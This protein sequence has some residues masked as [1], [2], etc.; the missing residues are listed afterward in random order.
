MQSPQRKSKALARLF[1]AFPPLNAADPDET[2]RRYFEAIDDF[3][4]ELVDEAVALYTTGNIPGFDGKFVPTPPML[5]AGCRKAAEIRARKAYLE[6]LTQPALP[7]PEVE[8]TLEAQQRVRA[9]MGQAVAALSKS[10][11]TDDAA[12]EL[13]KR[14]AKEKLAKH[15]AFFAE[16][17]V[18]TDGGVGR[19]SKSLARLIGYEVGD[20]DG[21]R[22][23]A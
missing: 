10:E 12:V 7:A 6:R 1:S 5:A 15:D 8:R 17:F 23:V 14:Q 13:A 9:L 19:V 22:E 4:A 18:A 3:D 20:E 16:D 11:P 2:L 21:D